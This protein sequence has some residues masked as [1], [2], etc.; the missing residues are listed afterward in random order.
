M[1]LLLITVHLQGDD[2]G[3]NGRHK[4]ALCNCLGTRLK[5][6]DRAESAL[7]GDDRF[8]ETVPAVDFDLTHALQSAHAFVT[9]FW[10]CSCSLG[11][12]AS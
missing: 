8:R 2:Q 4:G 11:A 1:L 6:C 10:G 7:I 12:A 9:T 5:G 3:Q